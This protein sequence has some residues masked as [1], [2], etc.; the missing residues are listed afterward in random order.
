MPRHQ[1]TSQDRRLGTGMAMAKRR[2]GEQEGQ[3]RENIAKDQKKKKEN[4][5][6]IASF[7][8]KHSTG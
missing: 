5:D 2:W 4:F 3:L 7:P 6:K 1:M 8:T